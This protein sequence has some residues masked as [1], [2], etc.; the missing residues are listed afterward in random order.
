[1]TKDE[2]TSYSLLSY[3]IAF[4]LYC[5]IE[6]ILDTIIFRTERSKRVPHVKEYRKGLLI[7]R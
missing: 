3:H 1:M 4:S 7:Y 5:P 2:D 6:T